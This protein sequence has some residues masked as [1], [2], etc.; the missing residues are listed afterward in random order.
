[1]G[2]MVREPDDQTEEDRAGQTNLPQ[3][4][5]QSGQIVSEAIPFQNHQRKELEIAGK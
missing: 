1:M 3:I 2:Q 5:R 4:K